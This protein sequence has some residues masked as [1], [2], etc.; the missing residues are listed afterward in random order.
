MYDHVYT[1]NCLE[2]IDISFPTEGYTVNLCTGVS[3]W[4]QLPFDLSIIEG[5]SL[6]DKS[7]GYSFNIF[8]FAFSC[9]LLKC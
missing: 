3:I 4:K 9:V 8:N 6:S 1:I 2:T 7:N 5:K